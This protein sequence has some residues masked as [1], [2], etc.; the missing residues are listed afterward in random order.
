MQ[1]SSK[2]KSKK[3]I[4]NFCWRTEYQFYKKKSDALCNIFKQ[5]IDILSVSETKIDDTFHLALFCV[6]GYSTPYRLDR[7]CIGGKP[8]PLLYEI[9]DIPS[10]Q[11]KLEFM[12]NEA[13][14][15]I[16]VEINPRKNVASLVL[17]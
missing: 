14:E 8:L 16:C 11:I 9:D 6:E 10:K 4:K 1:Y 12:E 5:K 7:T 17:S 3:F 2:T 15:K 13:F